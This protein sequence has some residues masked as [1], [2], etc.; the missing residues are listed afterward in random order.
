MEVDCASAM[1]RPLELLF[2]PEPNYWRARGPP[3]NGVYKGCALNVLAAPWS[4]MLSCKD[5]QGEGR[6]AVRCPTQA[7]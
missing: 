6:E 7:A 4:R 1:T 2:A 5:G 3:K